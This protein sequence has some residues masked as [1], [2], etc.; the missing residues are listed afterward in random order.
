LQAVY[1]HDGGVV[2]NYYDVMGSHPGSNSNTPDQ[3]W[4]DSPGSGH[5]P[6]IYASQEGT[7][8]R[9]KASFYFRRIEGQHAVMEA[10]GEGAKQ[11]WLTEFGWS[12]YNV[13]PGYEY[14]QLISAELQ[15]QYLV[16]AFEKGKN[17][18]PWMGV[19]AVWNLNFSTIK[20][21][22]PTDE[23]VPWAVLNADFSNRAAF[24]ALKNMPK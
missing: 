22:S 18:Y 11:I 4:P 20:G 7:C 13:A 14:G 9:N 21:I 3:L 16:R 23:K 10:N 19:M 6:P 5:C 17:D 12:T 8:W 15:A 24:T 1:A 2:K